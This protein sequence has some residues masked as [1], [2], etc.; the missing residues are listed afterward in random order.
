MI[1]GIAPLLAALIAAGQAPPAAAPAPAGQVPVFRAATR[2]VE[3]NVVVH[4]AHGQPVADLKKE[5]FTLTEHGKPQALRFFSMASAAVPATKPPV[6][7][8][9][10]FSNRQ[11]AD[12]GVPPCVT[13]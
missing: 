2:L 13:I 1:I 4:D 5:D 8:P 7:P 11:T 9:H 3:V 6:L 12:A 10:V